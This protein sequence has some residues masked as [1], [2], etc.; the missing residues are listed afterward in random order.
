[1]MRTTRRAVLPL[2]LI[3]T[4]GAATPLAA[5]DFGVA[6]DAGYLGLN[7]SQTAKAVY[8]SSGGATFGG[9]LRYQIDPHFF[10]AAG[11]RAFSKDGTRVFLKDATAP[12]QRLSDE[13]VKTSITPIYATVG[14]RI[15]QFGLVAPYVGI[16][17]GVT[18]Y[19][20]DDTV[21]G[22]TTKFDASK[23]SWHALAGIEVGTGLVRFG[24]EGSYASVPNTLGTCPGAITNTC[25][26]K[27][28][29]ETDVGGFSILGKVVLTTGGRKH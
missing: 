8:D 23:P 16:G 24:L 18:R 19:H 2:A 27:I 7:Y 26:S 20:E 4:A 22:I 5:G 12:V 1:M 29:D 10:V 13:P 17:G 21:A 3:L 9:E 14:Y 25:V 11:A 6:L 15:R 28:Y